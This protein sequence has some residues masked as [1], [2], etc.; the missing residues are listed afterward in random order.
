MA[1]IDCTI[2][3]QVLDTKVNIK[4]YFPTDLPAAVGNTVNG[5]LTLLHGHAGCGADWME[6]TA[7]SRYANDN[8]F[9]LIAPSC[10]NSFYHDMAYGGAWK[11]FVTEEMPKALGKIFHLP[12]ER[13]KNYIA[14]LSMGGYGA[15]Y[16][17]MSRPDL[18]A[19]CASFSG[20]VDVGMMLNAAKDSNVASSF[21]PV[22]GQDLT[23]KPED[24]LLCL[25]QKI[26][27]LPP[28]QQ[29]KILLTNGLQ[30]IVP[31]QI[32]A[33]NDALHA[34]CRELP[35]AQYLRMEWNGV[36]EWNF[37]DRSLVYAF[38]YFLDN[39]YAAR[40]IDDWRTEMLVQSVDLF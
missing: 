8:G 9:V 1:F 38:D 25:V 27:A 29:P 35:L 32:K 28:Q 22:L 15:L 3:S 24:N 10:E 16:L 39:K 20:A 23:L 36:H 21:I 26:A 33:Q 30:D 11:T 5:V 37:W 12:R 13:E 19:G 17:A 2:A 34:V 40:K 18:Y 6:M 4:L 14:G 7:A 31:Y